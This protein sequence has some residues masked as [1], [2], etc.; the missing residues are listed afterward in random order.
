M[1]AKTQQVKFTIDG[2]LE[3]SFNRSVA[4]ASESF[5]LLRQ[6]MQRINEASRRI[7]TFSRLRSEVKKAG[8]TMKTAAAEVK[9]LKKEILESDNPTD[10]M[11]RNLTKAEKAAERAQAAFR[12]KAQALGDARVALN[13]MGLRASQ[14]ATA[15]TNLADA[16]RRV[17]NEQTRFRNEVSRF[18][19]LG[20]R[21]L[22]EINAEQEKVRRAYQR[23]AAS[24]RYSA[25]E[26]RRA[27]RATQAQLANLRR[28]AEGLQKVGGGL[29]RTF[30]AVNASIA[31]FAGYRALNGVKNI[32]VELESAR[33]ALKA[34][35]SD[36]S[37]ANE[38]KFVDEQADRLGQSIPVLTKEYAKLAASTRGTVLEGQNT[39]D[40]FLAITEAATVLQ[41]SQDDLG[42]A[43]KA[44]QQVFS[45]GKVQAEELR[46]QLGERIPGAVQVM[47]R[48]LNV[49]TKELDKMMERGELTSDVMV[50][51]A[52]QLQSEYAD[53]VPEAT[54]TARAEFAR[55]ENAITRIADRVAQSGFLD[56]LIKGANDLAKTLSS[57]EMVLAAE[58]LGQALGFIIGNAKE[59]AIALVG[60]GAARFVGPLLNSIG[61]SALLAARNM[62]TLGVA[63]TATQIKMRGA[64]GAAV[65]LRGAMA[66]L[67]GPAGL[68]ILAATALLTFASNA[69]ASDYS[70]E[71][72]NEE[73]ERLQGNLHT[74][75]R[76]EAEKALKK[77]EQAAER[78]KQR[79]MD[80]EYQIERITKPRSARDLDAPIFGNAFKD[81]DVAKKEL[82]LVNRLIEEY[83]NKVDEVSKKEKEVKS[84][85][86]RKNDN[87]RLDLRG[88]D[89]EQQELQNRFKLTQA[90][91]D[92]QKQ[93][94]EQSYEDDLISLRNYYRKKQSLDQS[95]LDNELR[96]L[97]NRLLL[98]E[99]KRK[100]AL[101]AKDDDP[102]KKKVLINLQKEQLQVEADILLIQQKKAAVAQDATR[103]RLNAEKQLN[104]ELAEV[105]RRIL[106]AEGDEFSVRKQEI[107]LQYA[108]LIKR[109]KLMN[110]SEGLSLVARLIDLE[111]AKVDFD[112]I[113]QQYD[114]LMATL[115]LKEQALQTQVQA[116]L[117]GE[118]EARRQVIQLYAAT[119]KE[120]EKLI[121]LMAALAEKT[122]DPVMVQR[123]EELKQKVLE[124]GSVAD[125][126]LKRIAEQIENQFAD[127]FV[128]AIDEM[129]RGTKDAKTAF[130]DFARDFLR[131][132]AMM[133]IK[134]Q[135]L[136][137]LQAA[138]G[139]G[140]GAIAGA[141]FHTGGH[142]GRGGYKRLVPATAFVGAPRYHT[143]GVAGLK[144]NEVPSV[145]QKGE[146]VATENSPFHPK[147]AGNGGMN[148]IVGFDKEELVQQALNSPEGTK[149]QLA[150]MGANKNQIKTVLS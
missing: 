46:G 48:A 126:E 12:K 95:S 122:G 9:K 3:A 13:N 84:K 99:K 26:V 82:E 67:G 125:Q 70:T 27:W 10:K 19:A 145:L 42:G 8:A 92:R 119:G 73:L 5:N 112:V 21:P 142:V 77:H 109:L 115:A 101:E 123:V 118:R 47:A 6:E 89:I 75:E 39:R 32:A 107:E 139:A 136:N 148:L 68:I 44:V 16:T 121:P 83:K 133:I 33:Q 1:V 71:S 17:T 35:V 23:I 88:F 113:E 37:F 143:G 50:D 36:S 20:I 87:S 56:G 135:I 150:W 28:E 105:R 117:L 103:A 127:G 138:G 43:L 76:I 53:K 134:Q 108:D 61:A 40:V 63:A 25:E 38:L 86:S 96:Q 18:G 93:L 4:S 72:L 14:I 100:E 52:R 85:R 106:A 60:I 55:F 130:R 22:R 129:T 2:E 124:L 34:S 104:L 132:I 98:I 54:K 146:Y 30:L 15:Q 94:L 97:E 24:G 90:Y 147:N 11:V 49:S 81:L 78:L 131:Q 144:P 80:L 110:D 69:D 45:K 128:N 58:S 65:A 111:K 64:A 7:E 79:I 59:L 29:S 149:V 114:Q 140:S 41:L 102:N 74:L 66:A 120:V 51:F 116:G 91:L 57:P 141:F 62:A 137:M 31:A